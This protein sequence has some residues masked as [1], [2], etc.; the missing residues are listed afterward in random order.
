MSYSIGLLKIILCL[1]NLTL[2]IPELLLALHELPLQHLAL[3]LQ[4]STA[5]GIT[6]TFLVNLFFQLPNYLLSLTTTIICRRLKP[7]NNP[8]QSL[9]LPLL[10]P[11]LLHKQPI[12]PLERPLRLAPLDLVLRPLLVQLPLLL[13]ERLDLVFVD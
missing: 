2:A 7:A 13:L 5:T 6:S 12:L 1:L 4:L 11:D 9:D 3:P 8:P 10:P